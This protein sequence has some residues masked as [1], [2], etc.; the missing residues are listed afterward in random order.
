MATNDPRAMATHGSV[1]CLFVSRVLHI[2]LDL[3][4]IKEIAKYSLKTVLSPSNL[5]GKEIQVVIERR[6]CGISHLY[7]YI[8][9]K[10]F[11]LSMAVVPHFDPNR[12]VKIVGPKLS[13]I[14]ARPIAKPIYNILQA[15]TD[16][17][18]WSENISLRTFNGS[19][20][21][22]GCSSLLVEL[23]AFRSTGATTY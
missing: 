16:C 19:P 22:I 6:R 4:N 13:S 5:R 15:P 14:Q 10:C 12:I 17:C 2:I 8:L 9:F 23:L 21:H 7:L 11:I 1:F 20:S 18:L 3:H